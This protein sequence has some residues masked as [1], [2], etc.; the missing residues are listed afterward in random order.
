MIFRYFKMHLFLQF[1]FSRCGILRGYFVGYKHYDVW[2]SIA[3]S[4]DECLMELRNQSAI[5]NY[6]FIYLFSTEMQK[7]HVISEFGWEDGAVRSRINLCFHLCEDYLLTFSKRGIKYYILK[8]IIAF[9]LICRFTYTCCF[10]DKGF[11]SVEAKIIEIHSISFFV[12]LH[13]SRK[14]LLSGWISRWASYSIRQTYP[15]FKSHIWIYMY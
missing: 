6:L 1:S 10:A 8:F 3:K 15:L 2:R 5:K 4:K 12:D 7:M 14:M 11:K 13:F 9:T